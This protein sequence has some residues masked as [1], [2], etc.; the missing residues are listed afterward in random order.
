MTTDTSLM[1]D[2]FRQAMQRLSA[3]VCVLTTEHDGVR[4]GLT[5]TAVCSLTADPAAV[6][7]CINRGVGAHE[8]ILQSKRIGVNV[9]SFAQKPIAERFAGMRGAVGEDRFSEGHWF[10]AKT[11]A[12]LL[13]DA[14]VAMDCTI[15]QSM[16]YHSHTILICAVEDVVLS[17]NIGA[18]LYGNRG[19]H[20]MGT[21]LI[22]H[23][24]PATD[25]PDLDAFCG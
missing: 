23:S 12:P 1:S 3:S 15:A 19:F 18:L 24:R 7:V 2:R 11:G 17:H 9:L 16:T 5:A 13:Q 14:V 20:A 10:T 25:C 8:P 21:S 4:R 6:L 22:D